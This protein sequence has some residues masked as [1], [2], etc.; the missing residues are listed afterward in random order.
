MIDGPDDT[1]VRIGRL[2]RRLPYEQQMV[3]KPAGYRAARARRRLLHLISVASASSPWWQR[4]LAT[5]DLAQVAAGDLSSLP[6]MTRAELM[7]HGAAGSV[8]PGRGP[9]GPTSG[10][11]VVH[12][13]GTSGTAVM[14]AWSEAGWLRM[15]LTAMRSAA[16][17]GGVAPGST[18]TVLAVFGSDPGQMSGMVAARFS[19]P[20][21]RIVP[22]PATM[23]TTDI[24]AMVEEQQPVELR[25]YPSVLRRL[26]AEVLQRGCRWIPPSISVSGEVL[27]PAT[28]AVITAAFGRR[29]ANAWGTTETGWIAFSGADPTRMILADDACIVENVDGDLRPVPAGVPGDAVLVTSLLNT[30]QPVLRY[31]VDDVVVL[32]PDGD[33]TAVTVLGR[34]PGRVVVG[35]TTVSVYTLQ[36]AV[37]RALP[38]P[39]YQVHLD[40]TG[41]V[42]EVA[43]PAGTLHLARRRCLAEQCS[44]ALRQAGVVAA[45]AVV[46]G[47][48]AVQ[49]A[50]GKS[51][52]IVASSM[53]VGQ[54]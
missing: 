52:R 31:R 19:S 16:P 22:V 27:T 15:A 42:V 45:V 6:V 46:R 33:R 50:S 20:M 34:A 40:G 51:P 2:V 49:L 11:H 41:V 21:L 13:S 7:E 23:P 9:C 30:G 44:R 17:P 24:L 47:E 8:G 10:A 25:G 32:E 54:P 5:A 3:A 1:L 35:G 53:P 4:R 29:P 12:T 38:Y 48:R 39:D 37:E 26:A 28:S 14:V 36:G 43:D 18:A